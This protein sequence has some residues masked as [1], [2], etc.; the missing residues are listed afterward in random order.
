MKLV[1]QNDIIDLLCILKD[2][3]PAI[4]GMDGGLCRELGG[5]AQ[6]AVDTLRDRE[7]I[8]EVLRAPDQVVFYGG[9]IPEGTKLYTTL[10]GENGCILNPEWCRFQDDPGILQTHYWIVYQGEVVLSYRGST[11][12]FWETVYCKHR[13]PD[14]YITWIAP[15][16]VPEAPNETL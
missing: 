6:S 10:I 2:K 13:Y 7:P 9:G 11:G 4:N 3:L 15:I 8:G 16:G 12:D 5:L 14:E 1:T